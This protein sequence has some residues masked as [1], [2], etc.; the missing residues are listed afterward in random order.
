[1]PNN[2]EA[3]WLKRLHSGPMILSW[4]LILE[5]QFAHLLALEDQGMISRKPSDIIPGWVFEITPKGIQYLMTG[6][7]TISVE[8]FDEDYDDDLD[9]D[10]L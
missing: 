3:V 7:N 4:A 1:M 5:S 2:P 6:G 8:D 9:D 10:E